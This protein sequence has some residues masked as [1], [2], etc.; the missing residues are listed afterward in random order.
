MEVLITIATHETSIWWA[1]QARVERNIPLI[2][3]LIWLGLGTSYLIG[4]TIGNLVG[5]LSRAP[6]AT[7]PHRCSVVLDHKI[8]PTSFK[9]TTLKLPFFKSSA[10]E[11]SFFLTLNFDIALFSNCQLRSNPLHCQRI[12]IKFLKE[13]I[14]WR[15]KIY[16]INVKL[17][18]KSFRFRNFCFVFRPGSDCQ[19]ILQQVL[20]SHLSALATSF[21]S[22]GL[23]LIIIDPLPRRSFLSCR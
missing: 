9:L 17:R 5:D 13:M 1:S 8:Q 11:L 7:E 12:Y 19:L 18:K 22:C 10:L 16:K 6:H 21:P 14:Q 20:T 3:I 2:N 23:T 4:D 15:V